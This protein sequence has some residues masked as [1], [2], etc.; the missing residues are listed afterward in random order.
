[1]VET[2]RVL[3]EIVVANSDSVKQIKSEILQLKRNECVEAYKQG[4]MEGQNVNQSEDYMEDIIEKQKMIDKSKKDMEK[5]EVDTAIK[6]LNKKMQKKQVNT[7]NVAN[8][9]VGNKVVNRKSKKCRYFNWGYCKYKT[10]CRYV[11]PKKICDQYPAS[12]KCDDVD[13]QDRH[14]V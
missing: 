2:Q 9:T 6:E 13:C 7:Q 8:D 4:T 14:P 1:M 10:K 12:Q 11:H 5:K 3:E